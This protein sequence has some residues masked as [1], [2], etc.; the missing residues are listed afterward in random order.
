MGVY[1]D[2]SSKLKHISSISSGAKSNTGL[3]LNFLDLNPINLDLKNI[4]QKIGVHAI[5]TYKNMHNLH[6]IDILR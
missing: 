2:F 1:F 6:F 4:N 3:E 5:I